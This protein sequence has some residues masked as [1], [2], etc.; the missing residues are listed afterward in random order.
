MHEIRNEFIRRTALLDVSVDVYR[1]Y[2]E[3]FKLKPRSRS[4]L[5]GFLSSPGLILEID[6]IYTP[7]SA[8]PG[9]YNS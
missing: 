2:L 5:F 8:I 6:P 4:Y 9:F 3:F 1:V 7:P